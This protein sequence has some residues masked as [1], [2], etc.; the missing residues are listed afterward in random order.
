[1]RQAIA[2]AW[3][4]MIVITFMM[5]FIAYVTIQI[6]Y[7]NAFKLKTDMVTIIEQYDGLNTKTLTAIDKRIRASGY[8]NRAFCNDKLGSVVLGVNGTNTPT[9]I[10]TNRGPYQWCIAREKKSATGD[11]QSRYYYTIEVF[12]NF[13]L[14]VLGDLYTFRVNGATDVIYYPTDNYFS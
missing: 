12:F 7:S 6:N 4:Y 13:G 3:V 2:G 8:K 10:K 11:M 5:I 9:D 1:M 14:P